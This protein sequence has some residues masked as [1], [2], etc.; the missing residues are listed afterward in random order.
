M[1]LFELFDQVEKGIKKDFLSGKEKD[2]ALARL[3]EVRNRYS[4]LESIDEASGVAAGLLE[5]GRK[6]L[7]TSP[8]RAEAVAMFIR[9]AN[10]AWYDLSG[11]LGPYKWYVR[12]FFA[13]AIGFFLLAPQFYP[14]IM[15]LLFILP[16]FLGIRGIKTRTVTGFTMTAMIF[17]VS[18]LAGTAGLRSFVMQGLF[19]NLEQYAAQLGSNYHVPQGIAAGMVI[20]FSV[21]SMISIV[22]SVAGAIVGVKH[23]DLFV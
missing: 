6:V 1:A 11:R 18:L 17:P 9:Y 12:C 10:A 16:V 13:S 23:R 21:V 19:G 20:V 22:A 4:G 15:A 8:L 2:R 7:T 3:A 5:K 14:A